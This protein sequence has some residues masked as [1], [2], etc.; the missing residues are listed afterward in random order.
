MTAPQ[1]SNASR[2]RQARRDSLRELLSTQGHEQHVLVLLGKLEDL[3]AE[4]DSVEYQR[5]KAVIDT[6][7]KLINKYL[8]DDKEPQDLNIG[9]QDEGAFKIQ[10]VRRTIVDSES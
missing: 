2:I 5:I 8:P 3:S 1:V 10:E 7:M 6:K 4:L 9:N